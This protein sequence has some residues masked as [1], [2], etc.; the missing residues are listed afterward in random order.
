MGL[1]H[2]ACLFAK[3]LQGACTSATAANNTHQH[4]PMCLMQSPRQLCTMHLSMRC[5]Q[6]HT[7]V[8]DLEQHMHAR[9]HARKKCLYSVQTPHQLQR[10]PRYSH[11]VCIDVGSEAVSNAHWRGMQSLAALCLPCGA[12]SC[13]L[14][15]IPP[16]MAPQLRWLLAVETSQVQG[17]FVFFIFLLCLYCFS[18]V[19]V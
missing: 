19:F 18:V 9:M 16:V 3:Q 15:G 1:A 17:F 12:G 11:S 4:G 7:R 10:Q 6:Q 8:Q 5:N 14:Q 13:N 2:A